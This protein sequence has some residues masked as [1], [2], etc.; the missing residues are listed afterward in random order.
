MPRVKAR[1]DVLRHV[2]GH[3]GLLHN[4]LHEVELVVL[5]LA[6]A[7]P[8]RRVLRQQLVPVERVRQ[9]LPGG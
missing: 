1:F 2:V 6:V 7:L 8:E 4:E 3:L 5:R 9:L